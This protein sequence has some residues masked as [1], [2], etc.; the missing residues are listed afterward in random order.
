MESGP[1]VDIFGGAELLVHKGRI[2]QDFDNLDQC[3]QYPKL[4]TCLEN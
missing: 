4:L 3:C 2:A 1:S